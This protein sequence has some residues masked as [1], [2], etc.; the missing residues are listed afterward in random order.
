MNL[1]TTCPC[2]GRQLS[3]NSGMHWDADTRALTYRGHCLRLSR[4]RA[5]IFDAMWRNRGKRVLTLQQMMDTV[6]ADDPNGGPESDN[7]ISV[8][9]N[10]MKK[11]LAPFGL[12]ISGYKG[13]SLI[14]TPIT[15]RL[16][17]Q[18]TVAA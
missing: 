3:E 10:Q 14:D 12:S 4:I 17:E 7:I 11:L 2:C 18:V 1:D 16:P 13:Y 5:A 6:Y 8:Q 15:A 9:V